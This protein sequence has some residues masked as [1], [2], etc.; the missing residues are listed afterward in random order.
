MYYIYSILG[1][2]NYFKS[3]SSSYTSINLNLLYIFMQL[4]IL[5]IYINFNI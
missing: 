2:M 3:L 5:F 1:S 4:L